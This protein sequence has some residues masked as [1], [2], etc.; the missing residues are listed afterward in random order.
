MCIIALKKNDTGSRTIKVKINAHQEIFSCMSKLS[1]CQ[2]PL[3]IEMISKKQDQSCVCS[4]ILN[5]LCLT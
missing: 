1:T 3:N 4:I 5:Y 2:F